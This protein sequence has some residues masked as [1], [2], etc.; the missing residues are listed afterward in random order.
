MAANV[1]QANV[2]QANTTS[3]A[4]TTPVTASAPATRLLDRYDAMQKAP[5][6]ST[7]TLGQ[8]RNL[9]SDTGTAFRMARKLQRMGFGGAAEKLALAGGTTAMNEPAIKT[10]EFI[11][12]E[13]QAKKAS[14]AEAQANEDLK[15]RQFAFQNKLLDAQN[16]A[17]ASGQFDFTKYGT[18]VKQ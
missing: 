17:L 8:T 9:E 3:M 6:G 16:K 1:P 14:T 2:P 12:L 10:Q 11:G 15:R 18:L 4:S 7:S 13:E 5:M